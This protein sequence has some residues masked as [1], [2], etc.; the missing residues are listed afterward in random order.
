M[1]TAWAPARQAALVTDEGDI[2]TPLRRT[3]DRYIQ[4]SQELYEKAVESADDR[5]LICETAD[6]YRKAAEAIQ[7]LLGATP[8]GSCTGL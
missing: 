2:L 3:Y 4:K 1:T 7:G 8:G 5:K 6:F